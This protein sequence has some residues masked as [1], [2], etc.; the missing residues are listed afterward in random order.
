MRWSKEAS[1]EFVGQQSWQKV[2][3]S[4]TLPC[5]RQGALSNTQ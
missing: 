2:A 4:D 5:Q 1:A 3:E